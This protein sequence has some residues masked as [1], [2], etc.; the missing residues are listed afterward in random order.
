MFGVGHAGGHSS[1]SNDVAKRPSLEAARG[2]VNLLKDGPTGYRA[3]FPE[4]PD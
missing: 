3:G 1:S 2:S 4:G